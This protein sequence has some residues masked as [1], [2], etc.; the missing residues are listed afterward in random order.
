[1]YWTRGKKIFVAFSFFLYLPLTVHNNI[2]DKD[3]RMNTV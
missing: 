3:T 1:M 2:N